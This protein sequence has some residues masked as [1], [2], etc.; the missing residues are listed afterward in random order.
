[1]IIDA[2]NHILPIAWAIVESENENSWIWFSL[3][4]KTAIPELATEAVT[5]ISDRDK[6]LREA[7][8]QL[9]PLCLAAYCCWHL[10]ENLVREF[11]RP[12]NQHFWAIARAPF[13]AIFNSR[14]AELQA[15]NPNAAAYLAA[16]PPKLW[17]K[18]HFPGS[19]FNHDTSNIA[20]STN[21]SIKL[22]REAPVLNCLDGIWHLVM[23]LRFQ[24]IEAIA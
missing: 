13:K 12:L 3:H 6:G 24:Q 20:E 21:S 9:G 8:D 10:K 16:I 15:V 17:V 2:D 19:R 1:V 11:R 7:V 22:H 23:G 14:L 4:L 18:A 5:A